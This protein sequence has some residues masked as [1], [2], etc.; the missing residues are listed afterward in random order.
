ME[1]ETTPSRLNCEFEQQ[2][3]R[4][5]SAT[6]ESMFDRSKFAA[7][8][9]L[10][11]MLVACGGG[12][13]STIDPKNP[14]IKYVGTYSGCNNHQELTTTISATGSYQAYIDTKTDFYQNSDCTGAIVGT[15]TNSSPV[16]ATYQATRNLPVLGVESTLQNLTIDTI[17]ISLGIISESL[18]GSGVSGLCV[19]YIDGSYCYS[20]PPTSSLSSEDGLYLNGNLLYTLTLV[21]GVYKAD[22]VVLTKIH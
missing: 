19:N 4:M 3:K 12:G 17:N 13:S 20:N 7:T 10:A 18:T 2:G 14:M 9:A 16:T 1:I 21:N 6:R 15:H 8:I 5:N 22:S 11:T